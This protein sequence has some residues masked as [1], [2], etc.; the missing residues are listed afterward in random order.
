[1]LIGDTAVDA[2]LNLKVAVDVFSS[3]EVKGAALSVRDLVTAR[4]R[5]MA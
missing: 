3:K 4:I 5:T 2:L 1:M